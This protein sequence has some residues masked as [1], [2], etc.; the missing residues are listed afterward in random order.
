MRDRLTY[1]VDDITTTDVS[2]YDLILMIFVTSIRR[3]GE[4]L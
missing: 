1:V 2:D 3:S 4:R